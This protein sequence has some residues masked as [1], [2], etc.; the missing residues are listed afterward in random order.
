VLAVGERR[1]CRL[2][3]YLPIVVIIPALVRHFQCALRLCV[4][5]AGLHAV[6]CSWGLLCGMV[7]GMCIGCPGKQYTWVDGSLHD[8][9]KPSSVV[10]AVVCTLAADL[11]WLR[12]S[13]RGQQ[14]VE[15]LDRPINP[16]QPPQP[17]F[18][19]ASSP[20]N[21]SHA[22]RSSSPQAAFRTLPPTSSLPLTPQ[23]KRC[24]DPEIRTSHPWF[25][26][27]SAPQ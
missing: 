6:S 12:K 27:S 10:H 16:T 5:W 19:Y 2:A 1:S 4:M 18:Q 14:D 15:A 17:T 3:R 20:S 21:I 7:G 11:L 25:S 23:S 8:Q 22:K 9:V 24:H 13:R 26:H